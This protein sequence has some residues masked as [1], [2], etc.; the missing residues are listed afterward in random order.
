MV[1]IFWE[2]WREADIH[3]NQMV[4]NQTDFHKASYFLADIQL[5]TL[6]LH[7]HFNV[8]KWL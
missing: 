8:D 4:E 7:R 1:H 2:L 5:S 6:Q 3:M